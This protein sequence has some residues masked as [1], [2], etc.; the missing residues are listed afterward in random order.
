MS[1]N[2]L[3]SRALK[4]CLRDVY[5]NLWRI[6]LTNLI[7]TACFAPAL[8]IALK[9]RRQPSPLT[10]LLVVAS[11]FLTAPALGG[12]FHLSK[13]IALN[14]PSM[15][16]GDFWEGVKTYWRQSLVV[17]AVSLVIPTLAIGALMFYAQLAAVHL[18]GAV[19]WTLNLVAL[20]VFLM[21][22]LYFFPLLVSQEQTL[23]A[24]VKTSLLL[25]LDN[26]RFSVMAVLAELAFLAAFL[27][28]GIVFVGG[29]GTIVLLQTNAFIEVAKRYTEED[30]RKE[31][32]IERKRKTI[33]QFLR[34]IFFPWRYE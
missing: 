21:V 31:R 23:S 19:F 8:L 14:D 3:A 12:M 29:V 20:F 13:K 30:V 32:K 34:D 27:L 10:L 22:Q 15:G 26:A 5:R 7:W 16:M 33:G 11:S 6:M 28:T 4:F 17:L 18:T 1:T 9:M 24:I 2:P 25:V